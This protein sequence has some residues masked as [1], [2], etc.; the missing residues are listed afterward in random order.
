MRK[1]H[2]TWMYREACVSPL[3]AAN[4]WLRI[5]AREV[6]VL[7]QMHAIRH[8]QQ[9]KVQSGSLMHGSDVI[10]TLASEEFFVFDEGSLQVRYLP[11]KQQP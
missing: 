6:L 4:G 5:L 7:T 3:G 9:T 11:G 2:T 1:R 10:L 8:D